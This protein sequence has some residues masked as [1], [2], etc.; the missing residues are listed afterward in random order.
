MLLI[1]R[2]EIAFLGI[3]G[4]FKRNQWPWVL[5]DCLLKV[6]HMVIKRWPVY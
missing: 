2:S 1:M 4:A 3:T 6:Y 5:Y